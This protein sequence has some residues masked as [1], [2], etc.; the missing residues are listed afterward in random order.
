LCPAVASQ[1]TA[2]HG[3]PPEPTSMSPSK[4]F[5]LFTALSSKKLWTKRDCSRRSIH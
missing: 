4:P 1:R 2:R 3:Y 5:H